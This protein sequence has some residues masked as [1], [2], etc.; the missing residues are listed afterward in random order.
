MAMYSLIEYSSNYYGT[1]GSSWFYSKDEA[2]DFD[3]GIV[4]NNAFKSF[5]YK[6]KLLGNIK[7]DHANR[8]FRNVTIAVALKYLSNFL[9]PLKM[10]LINCKVELK[11][12]WVKYFVLAKNDDDYDDANPSNIMFTMKDTKLYVPV[13]TLSAKDNQNYQKLLVKDLE[14]QC[15]RMN[16]IQKVR[17][18]T[19]QTS[20]DIF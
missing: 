7:A 4:N 17:V 10:P 20:I 19:R 6:A 9:Q 13:I 14:D 18:K 11:V 15:T 2:I 3:N 16:I 12:R 8:I 1:T 5:M